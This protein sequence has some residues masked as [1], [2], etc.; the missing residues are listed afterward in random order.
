M[1]FQIP[2]FINCYWNEL[3]IFLKFAA[4]KPVGYYSTGK[5]FL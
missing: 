2:D 5:F 1:L 3:K 4:V